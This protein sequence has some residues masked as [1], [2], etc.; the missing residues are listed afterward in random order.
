M[1][2]KTVTWFIGV[3]FNGP[4]ELEEQFNKWYNESHVPL[5]LKCK[6]VRGATRYRLMH[7]DGEQPTHV[8]KYL[9][10]DRDAFEEYLSNSEPAHRAERKEMWPDEIFDVKWRAAFEVIE[11]WE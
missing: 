2:D 7:G 4:P 5:V 6:G 11:N 1:K 3:K 10:E 8:A 9:F